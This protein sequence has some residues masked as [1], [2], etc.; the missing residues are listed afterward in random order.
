MG[1]CTPGLSCHAS[2]GRFSRQA[3]L[4]AVIWVQLKF[5]PLWSLVHGTLRSDRSILGVSLTP[6]KCSR[7]YGVWDVILLLMQSQVSLAAGWAG[8]VANETGYRIQ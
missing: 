4:N 3:S 2:Q 8:I 1:L 6:W 5:L 7:N